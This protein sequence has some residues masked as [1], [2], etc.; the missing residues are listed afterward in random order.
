MTPTQTLPPRSTTATPK[1]RLVDTLRSEWTKM[2][3]LR[4]TPI[5]LGVTAALVIG[6]GALIAYGVVTSPHH[7]KRF[8][9][10]PVGLIQG[11]WGLG[12]LAFMVL[13]VLVVSNEYS[14]GMIGPTLLAT[15]R[16]ARV[17]LAKVAVF[18]V[19]MFVVGD[20]MSFVNFFV[21]HAVVSGHPPFSDPSLGDHNVLRAVVGMGI[22]ATLVGLMGLGLGALLRHTAGAITAGVAVVFV[23]PIIVAILPSSWG[24]PIGEYWPTEAGSQLEEVARQANAL[25][26]WWG[27]GDMAL[28]V[29]ILLAVAG[30]LLV[31][32]DA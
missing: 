3:T 17:L 22:T 20:V 12:E 14:S 23:G 24:N 6:L 9:S 8:L 2:R 26:A 5:T 27:A 19:L 32:R 10:D 25:S 28:F 16:R 11:G 15:P 7:G 1:P 13:G 21:G 29:A 31:K 30:Y 18:S 4:S